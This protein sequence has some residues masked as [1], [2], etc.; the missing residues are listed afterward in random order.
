MAFKHPLARD[1]KVWSTG[2]GKGKSKRVLVIITTLELDKTHKKFKD[3]KVGA[4]SR[5]AKD[6]LEANPD[7]AVEYLLMNRPKSWAG[8]KDMPLSAST[9][10]AP[11]T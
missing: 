6:W 4:L 2:G 10:D 3:D 1:A 11:E 8:D 7:Q 9:E 5:A